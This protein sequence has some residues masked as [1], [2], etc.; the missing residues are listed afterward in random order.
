MIVYPSIELKSGRP[1]ALH[2]GRIDEAQVWHVDPVEAARGFAEAGASWLQVI[3]LDAAG[4][5]AGN[6]A[7]VEELIRSP[8]LPVQ[9]GGGFRTAERVADWIERGA[10]RIVLGT[11]AIWDAETV[12]ALAKRYPDQ[13]V[14]AIDIWDGQV[15]TEGWRTAS[16]LTPEAV[17]DGFEEAP[18]AGFLVTDIDNDVADAD[19]ALGLISGL[20]ARTRL[21]VIASGLVHSLDDVARL[22]YVKNLAGAVIGRSLFRKDFALGE[23]LEIAQPAPE[24]TAE[25]F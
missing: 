17:M 2:R 9:L 4:G 7:L 8:G 16:A 22:K 12:R 1:V 21:P 24:P 19:A 25:F 3:D 5:D 6:D 13:I 15:M 11:L 10:G 14:V 23:A 20:A 18:L